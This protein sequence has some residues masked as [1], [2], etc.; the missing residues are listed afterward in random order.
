MNQNVKK[1]RGF[2]SAFFALEQGPW[3]G[4]LAGWP[5]LPGNEYHDNWDKR[6]AFAIS[7]FLKMPNDVRIAM[8]LYAIQYTIKY[9]PNTLVRSLT[10][11]FL[12]GRGP[13]ENEYFTS[14]DQGVHKLIGDLDA[15]EEA[16]QMMKEFVPTAAHPSV[17]STIESK[18]NEEEFIYPSPF[19]N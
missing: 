16:K 1:L 2:F 14:E 15:K 3:A 12:F 5:G 6:F 4:F 8:M 17:N 13:K 18:E 7:L 11:A 19:N 9:G 10:P